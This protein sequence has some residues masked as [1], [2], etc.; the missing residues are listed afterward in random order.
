[1]NRHLLIP[2]AAL[3]L[4][5]AVS[6]CG[7]DA[8]TASEP[9]NSESST[10]ASASIVGVGDD[11][12]VAFAQQMI[13]HHRQAVDMAA[14]AG[15]RSTNPAVLD[16]AQRIQSAQEPEIEQM[17]GWLTGWGQTEMPDEMDGMDHGSMEGMMSDDDMASLEGLTGPAFDEAFI[18]MM[19]RHH[20]G[21][22]SMANTVLSDSADPNVRSMAEA[23]I[24]AQQD[25]IDE[26][27]NLDPGS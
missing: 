6:A 13:P 27:R 23:I 16:L 26:M 22:I 3:A 5:L 15:D 24:T 20:E 14:L 18:E 17:R 12:D 7:S 2:T 9:G 10:S 8:P 11:A 1:M 21:A 4:M 19:I 25:E